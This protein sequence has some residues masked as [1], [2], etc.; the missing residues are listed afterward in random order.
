VLLEAPRRA[1][2][3]APLLLALAAC[4]GLPGRDRPR[5]P[6]APATQAP[7][8]AL[9]A[10][11]AAAAAH[12]GQSAFRLYSTGVDGLLLRLELIASA[13]R[14]LDL[15]YYIFRGDESGRL[16]T[17]A[18][19]AA[20]QRGV[21]V[22]ILVDDGEVAK[23]DD[24]LYALAGDP[25][26]AI[27]VFNPWH[28]RGKSMTLRGLEYLTHHERL[29]YRMHN[30]LF[31]ADGALALIGGRNIGDQYFQVDP[32]AQ[33]ADDDALVAGP[34]TAALA[35]CFAQF[36]ASETAV[37]VE[38]LEPAR[39][40]D[41]AAARALAARHTAPQ[42]AAA[43]G[44]DFSARLAAGEPL[45]SALDGATPLTWASAELAR[46]LPDK[47]H[48]PPSARS[49][50]LM[51]APIAQAIRAT[52]TQFVMVTPYLVPTGGE[53]QLL[54][55]VGG[56]ARI[57][58]TSLEATTDPLAQAG[59]MHDRVPL[60]ESGVQLYELRRD[61]DSPRGTGQPAHMS[62]YGNL[63]LHA[64]LLVFDEQALYVGSMNYDARSR[65]LNTELG[66]IV[67]SPVLAGEALRRFE[68]M[69]QPAN[70][71]H[72]TLKQQGSDPQLVWSTQRA[73]RPVELTREPARS[74]WQRLEVHTLKLL[75]VDGE[76]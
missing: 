19:L 9:L 1:A 37:P 36:W 57:L 66:L 43:A 74:P 42:K 8:A 59:Y 76:L 56:H 65:R 20:A 51:F 73:G 17:E 32:D 29:D 58:T 75:P 72:V 69:T 31:I 18:L 11:A 67:H 3:A 62:R 55:E 41:A 54:E 40:R 7:N 64:K 10:P 50:S 46:D 30:K 44:S 47:R 24:Q 60:L 48:E 4:A 70:A 15:Q 26:V 71:Y 61:P 45:A 38:F 14:S 53:L 5:P 25:H 68:A 2:L 33:Y 34:V 22:R 12:P 23:G 39:L 21:R 13:H 63:G 16:L 27:R 28:Y 52:R 49:G 35:D 6:E